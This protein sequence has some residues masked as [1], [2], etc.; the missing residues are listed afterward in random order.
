MLKNNE[1]KRNVHFRKDTWGIVKDQENINK[2][3]NDS[4]SFRSDLL[5]FLKAN[6]KLK[7]NQIIDHIENS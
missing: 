6:P 2:F 4:I 7:C 1:T 3:V 5:L